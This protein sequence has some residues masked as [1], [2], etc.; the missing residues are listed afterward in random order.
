MPLLKTYH[1]VLEVIVD[2]GPKHPDKFIHTYV[3]M[4]IW[5]GSAIVL[6]RRLSA[7]VP[8]LI[9]VGMEGFN[10]ILDY[11]GEKE[12]SLHGTL[13]DLLATFLWPVCFFIALRLFPWL[14]GGEE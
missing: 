6:R 3:G 11:I 2:L 9:L 8:M 7:W 13:T 14:M 5:L 4:A 10:E 1:D 12:W